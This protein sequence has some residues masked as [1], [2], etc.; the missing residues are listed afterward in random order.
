MTGIGKEDAPHLEDEAREQIELCEDLGFKVFPVRNKIPLVTDWPNKAGEDGLPWSRANGFGIVCGPR[1]GVF[2]VDVDTQEGREYLAGLAEAHGFDLSRVP[3]VRTK[4]GRHYYFA[5]PEGAELRNSSRVIGPGI[6][7]RGEGGFVVGPGSEHPDGGL[8]AWDGDEP[9]PGDMAPFPELPSW[10]LDAIESPP[11][12]PGAG[13]GQWGQLPLAEG[14]GRNNWMASYIGG[15][16]AKG[17]SLVEVQEAAE[18][19]NNDPSIFQSPL[20]RREMH[21]MMG[22]PESL[23]GKAL[24]RREIEREQALPSS[25]LD[26]IVPL[27]PSE[28]SDPDEEGAEPEEEIPA[29]VSLAYIDAHPEILQP[30]EAIIPGLVYKGRTTLLSA[31]PKMG[32]STLIGEAVSAVS[33]GRDFLGMPTERTRVLYLGPDESLHDTYTRLKEYEAD[34]EGVDLWDARSGKNQLEEVVAM[35]FQDRDRLADTRMI[36]I[37]SLMEWARLTT[38]Q[39]PDDGDNAAWGG[40]IRQIVAFSHKHGIAVLLIHHARRS[41]GRARGASEI[42]AAVDGTC[43]LGLPPKASEGSS[44]RQVTGRGRFKIEGFEYEMESAAFGG[45]E[46]RLVRASMTGEDGNAIETDGDKMIRIERIVSHDG[47][48]SSNKVASRLG[49][50]KEAVL[51]LLDRMESDGRIERSEK[52][53][54]RAR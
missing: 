21:L 6:D 46:G 50:R 11:D 19:A 23:L 27:S 47:P 8:Y 14:D 44:R 2:V 32:K 33:S 42:E 49:G 41:D 18:K 25:V 12:I 13:G 15:L 34:P 51:E 1:S 16:V 45:V 9:D 53:W 20:S 35:Y 24:W 37:D 28:V 54:I 26:N 38:G 7:T 48:I 4:K 43:T 5:Y 10:I 22:K 36:V 29:I 40:I 30:P 31:A 52:G 3:A 17:Y 39:A